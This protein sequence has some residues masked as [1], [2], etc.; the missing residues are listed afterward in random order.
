[1]AK[2]QDKQNQKHLV[3]NLHYVAA[4]NGDARLSRAIGILL[5]SGARARKESIDTKKETPTSPLPA[6]DSPTG[7]AKEDDSHESE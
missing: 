4:S 6:R 2:K 5:R 1:V 7:G 3:V